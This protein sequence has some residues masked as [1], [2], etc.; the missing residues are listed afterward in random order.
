MNIQNIHALHKKLT[1][2]RNT[3]SYTEDEIKQRAINKSKNYMCSELNAA[4]TIDSLH[5]ES[6]DIKTLLKELSESFVRVKSDNMFEVEVMLLSQAQTLNVFFHRC[7][8]QVGNSEFMPHI[9][10]MSDLALRTQNNCRKTLLA[11]AEIKNPKRAT[12]IK[13][14][15]NA[16]GNQQVNNSE[17]SKKSANEVLNGVQHE[18]L[19]D[20]SKEKTIAIHPTL[21]TVE[22]SY[23][24]E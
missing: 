14:Q 17:N 9:Q 12:F 3:V 23:R 1:M 7:L 22:A 4:Y 5:G 18:S 6:M 11:L 19:D 16:I 21:A 13:Q 15:N 2:R 20:R 10:I 8:S 24:S